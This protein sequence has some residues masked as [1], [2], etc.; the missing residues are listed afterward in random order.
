[1]PEVSS[2]VL[3]IGRFTI[4]T[5][6][7]ALT[8]DGAYVP[9]RPQA[10]E[11]LCYLVKNSGHTVSKEAVFAEV[12]SGVSV[13][14]DSLVQCI[15]DIRQALEDG[16]HRIIKTLPRRGYLFVGVPQREYGRLL[17]SASPQAPA[18]RAKI[19]DMKLAVIVAAVMLAI[20]ATVHWFVMA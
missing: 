4:D 20:W 1:M 12:W 14:D 19:Y 13:T 17:G 9:L 2:P 6:R 18:K 5:D 8:R 16:E 15:R 11:V 7:R 10:M 3:Q